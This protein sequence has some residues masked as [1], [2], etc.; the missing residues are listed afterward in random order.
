MEYFIVEEG[1]MWNETLAVLKEKA[2]AGVDVRLIYDASVP[3]V[4]HCPVIMTKRYAARHQVPCIQ[5]AAF[6]AAYL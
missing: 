6:F 4:H 1:E 2:A 3:Y 5:S